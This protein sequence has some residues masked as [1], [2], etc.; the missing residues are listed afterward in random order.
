MGPS[1]IAPIDSGCLPYFVHAN[2]VGA[3]ELGMVPEET[4]AVSFPVEC[5]FRCRSQRE[6]RLGP[7]RIDVRSNE[8]DFKGFRFFVEPGAWSARDCESGGTPHFTLN[9]CNLNFDAPWPLERLSAAHDRSYRGRKMAAGYYLTDHFGTPAYLVGRGTQY[10]IF[11]EDFE[12]IL[13]PY[14]VK[15]LLTVYAM[16]HEMLHLKAAGVAIDGCGTLLVGRGGSGKTVLLSRLCQ[17]G[18]D[19]LSNTHCLLKGSTLIGISTA[20]RVRKDKFFTP[21]VM[22]RGLLPSVKA[23]EYVVDP[24]SDLRWRVVESAPVRSVCL[25]DYKESARTVIREIEGDTI[26]DYMEQFAL[27]INVY[28]LKEDMLDHLGG[29]VER[30]SLQTSRMRAQLRD[31]I[32]SS[33][34]YYI[35]CDA[36]DVRNL[37]ALRN[38]LSG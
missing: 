33:R 15:H 24:F 22:E 32:G 12:P 4:E 21:I 38:L 13:W 5:A 31:L 36:A 1:A 25:L 35:S 10:W 17:A 18:A 11:A 14:A 26:F 19:F 29:D 37:Q 3:R 6:I 30:F 2:G 20:M 27:A 23:G 34:C 8:P 9:L 28:G 16:E 7:V